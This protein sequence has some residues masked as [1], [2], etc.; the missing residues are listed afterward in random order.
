[1]TGCY[2]CGNADSTALDLVDG[3]R[4]A[5][6]VDAHAC[7]LRG[8]HAIAAREAREEEQERAL[9]FARANA[10]A[11]APLLLSHY[12]H[13]LDMADP[14]QRHVRD[15]GPVQRAGALRKAR[16]LRDLLTALGDE[17]AC[18]V[19]RDERLARV[20]AGR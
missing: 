6:C 11:L 13:A 7:N 18:K 10:D 3:R 5:V 12:E 17:S 4:A 2:F 19:A 20:E 15:V 16:A 14:S 9:A 8:A 1:M